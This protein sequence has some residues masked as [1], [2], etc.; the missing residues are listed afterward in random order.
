MEDLVD[1]PRNQGQPGLSH[2]ILAPALLSATNFT[3]PYLPFH[4]HLHF[5]FPWPLATDPFFF[6][7]TRPFQPSS[8]SEYPPD[9]RFSH[10]CLRKVL[11][12]LASSDCHL[13]TPVRRSFSTYSRASSP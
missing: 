7:F 8:P 4:L 5:H 2:H 1:K 9:R 3:K 6:S 12:R 10:S 11:N 13:L